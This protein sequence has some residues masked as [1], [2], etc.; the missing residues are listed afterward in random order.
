MGGTTEFPCTSSVAHLTQKPHVTL[1]CFPRWHLSVLSRRYTKVYQWNG[2]SLVSFQPLNSNLSVDMPM[3]IILTS[4][5][6]I[7]DNSS[8]LCRQVCKLPWGGGERLRMDVDRSGRNLR[9]SVCFRGEIDLMLWWTARLYLESS[10]TPVRNPSPT[11][12]GADVRQ[13]LCQAGTLIV[14]FNYE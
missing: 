3:C 6:A 1:M 10:S 9:G 7:R 2:V 4:W 8:P 11:Q 12:R 5:L 14:T 13:C